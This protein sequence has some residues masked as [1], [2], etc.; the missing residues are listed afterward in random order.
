MK[1]TLTKLCEDL[2]IPLWKGMEIGKLVKLNIEDNWEEEFEDK[3]SKIK[4][5]DNI[6]ADNDFAEDYPNYIRCYLFKHNIDTL[7]DKYLSKGKV[8]IKAR[9]G[10]IVIER[11]K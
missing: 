4:N 8:K 3:L 2:K 6:L 1:K 5:K 10:K 9:K 11:V 7:I